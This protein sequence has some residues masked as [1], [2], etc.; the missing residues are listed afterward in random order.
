[1]NLKVTFDTVVNA[2]KKDEIREEAKRLAGGAENN[3]QWLPH[4]RAAKKTVKERLTEEERKTFEDEV[5]EWTTNGVPRA[6][7]AE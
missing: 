1:L 5:D 7:Q 3:K 6:V 2:N 4:Y